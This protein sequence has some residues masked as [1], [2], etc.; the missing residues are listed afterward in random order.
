ML[1]ENALPA[2]PTALPLQARP[3]HA[4][5]ALMLMHSM[6]PFFDAARAGPTGEVI[7]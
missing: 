5:A 3:A 1:I 4:K 2:T 7:A 6:T